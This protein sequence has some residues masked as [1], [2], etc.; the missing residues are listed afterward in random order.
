MTAHCISCGAVVVWVTTM[1]GKSMPVDV[2]KVRPPETGNIELDN[3]GGHLVA[4]VVA[5]APWL[6]RS[7]FATCPFASSHRKR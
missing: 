4:K 7:H 2:A 1:N 3:T 5:P 6:Y